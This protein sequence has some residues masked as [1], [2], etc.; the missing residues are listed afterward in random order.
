[1]LTQGLDLA[2]VQPEI[3]ATDDRECFVAEDHLFRS[4]DRILKSK[5]GSL[6]GQ[7]ESF[8][9]SASA[10]A[11]QHI[12]ISSGAY[13]VLGHSKNKDMIITV[14]SVVTKVFMRST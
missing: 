11:R 2:E 6:E 12:V 3:V 7:L 8:G 4:C 5:L 10:Y 14:L 9:C 13:I 1:M